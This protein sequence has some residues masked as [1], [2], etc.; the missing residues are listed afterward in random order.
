MTTAMTSAAQPLII[1]LD[2][3]LSRAPAAWRGTT[4]RRL[5]DLFLLDAASYSDDQ[6]AVFDDVIS[7]LIEKIERRTLVEL[8][9]KLAQVENAPI[10]VV[11]TLARHSDMLVAGPLLEKSNV[12]TDADLVE[13]ADKDKRDPALLS[14]IAARPQLSEAVTEVLIRRGNAAIARRI[15]DNSDARISEASFA[16]IVTSIESDKELAAAIGRRADLP[17]ELRPWIDVALAAE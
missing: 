12:L 16:R 6:V 15:I 14:A 11:G 7:R 3:V 17:P 10:K 1:E 5:T 13:I 4:L 9:N 8:S 2:S